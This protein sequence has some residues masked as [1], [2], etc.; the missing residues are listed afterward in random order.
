MGGLKLQQLKHDKCGVIDP[1]DLLNRELFLMSPRIPK[2]L[3]FMQQ[4]LKQMVFQFK[5]I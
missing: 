5:E 1:Q 4:G 3:Y 2:I